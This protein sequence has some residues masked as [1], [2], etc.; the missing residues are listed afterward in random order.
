[1]G[2]E[3]LAGHVP[4]RVVL[5]QVS[6][7]SFKLL[8]GFRYVDVE[9]GV[10]E[11]HPQD[12]R[13][14][15]LASVPR[16]FR[17]FVGTHGRHTLAALLHDHQVRRLPNEPRTGYSYR[18]T[19]ADDRFLEML[20]SLGVPWIRRNLMWGAVHTATRLLH[21]LWLA[22]VALGVWFASSVYGTGTLFVAARDRDAGLAVVALLA[23]LA[24]AL[25]WTLPSRKPILRW[26][27]GVVVSYGVLVFIPALAV[28]GL[29]IVV[30]NVLDRLAGGQRP[31]PWSNPDNCA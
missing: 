18:R 11:V 12:L 13:C 22:R 26:W 9:G 27:C 3:S 2:F 20:W 25:L 16:P 31:P 23:P 6:D 4:A 14:T 1:M 5:E 29:A 8:E 30:H 19:E 7:R 17:W 28:N 10:H 24:G 21:H 15:D